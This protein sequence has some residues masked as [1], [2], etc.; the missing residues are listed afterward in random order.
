MK[1]IMENINNFIRSIAKAIRRFMGQDI[2]DAELYEEKYSNDYFY[3]QL[4]GFNELNTESRNILDSAMKTVIIE[5]NQASMQAALKMAKKSKLKSNIKTEKTA[6]TN[7][8][9]REKK[10]VKERA[11][12]DRDL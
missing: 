10:V 3:R 2:P 6:E 12:V 9:T 8:A 11:N 4:A 7:K 1:E 5:E